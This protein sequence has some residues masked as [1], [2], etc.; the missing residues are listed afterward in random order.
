MPGARVQAPDLRVRRRLAEHLVAHERSEVAPAGRRHAAVAI[1]IVGDEQGT[2]CFALTKRTAEMRAHAG[3]WALP[4]GRVDAGESAVQ[5]ALRELEEEVNLT[6]AEVLGLL[7]DYATRSGYVITPVVVWGGA[8]ADMAPNPAEVAQLH[9]VP[10]AELDRPDAP[11]AAAESPPGRPIIQWPLLGTLIHAPTGAVL[12]QL[13]EVAVHG[14]P[15][16]IDHFT[17]PRFAWR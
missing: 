12:Y 13:R 15:A 3:Q 10:L 16:R 17:E 8:A 9:R 11:I 5:A 7:D 4:G 1:A 2:A 6:G 14:R